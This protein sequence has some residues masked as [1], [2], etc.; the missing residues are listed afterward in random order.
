[1]NNLCKRFCE[2]I[3]EIISDQNVGQLNMISRD[4]ILYKMIADI[5]VLSAIILNGILTCFHS[6]STIGSTS[7]ILDANLLA[8]PQTRL[9]LQWPREA[10]HLQK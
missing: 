1:M 8:T 10:V 9:V 2:T 6:V 5:K 3:S 7:Q 4:F